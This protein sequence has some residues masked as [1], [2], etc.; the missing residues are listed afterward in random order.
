MAKTAPAA[1]QTAPAVSLIASS[2]GGNSAKK[3]RRKAGVID[4]R[5]GKT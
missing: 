4:P 1:D 2:I 3:R 5:L